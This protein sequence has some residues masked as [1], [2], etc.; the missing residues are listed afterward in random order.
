[1]DSAGSQFFICL[2]KQAFLDGQ[3]TAFGKCVDEESV[4]TVK[5]IGESATDASDRPKTAVTIQS[6]TV[7]EQP[8]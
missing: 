6:V 8:K 4:N 1:P 2:G 5:A 3:Y 7:A